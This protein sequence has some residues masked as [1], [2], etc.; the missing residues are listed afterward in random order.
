[1]RL[2]FVALISRRRFSGCRALVSFSVPVRAGDDRECVHCCSFA[3]V[4]DVT[5]SVLGVF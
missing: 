1:M 5:G 3:L 4:D 2:K